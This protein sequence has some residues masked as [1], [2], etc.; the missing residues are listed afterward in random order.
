MFDVLLSFKGKTIDINQR[1]ISTELFNNG[2]FSRIFFEIKVS[3]QRIR[4]NNPY[5]KRWM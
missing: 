1:Q 5:Q 4:I 2:S 3:N